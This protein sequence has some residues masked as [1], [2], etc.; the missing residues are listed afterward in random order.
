MPNLQERLREAA[1]EDGASTTSRKRKEPA[2]D[3]RDGERDKEKE[4]DRDRDRGERER[5]REKDREPHRERTKD[6]DR[7]TRSS[8][9]HRYDD[10]ETERRSSRD[11]GRE[12]E[13]DIDREKDRDGYRSS[14]H[15]RDSERDDRKRDREGGRDRERKS[16]RGDHGSGYWDEA[17]L[18]KERERSTSVYRD[19]PPREKR[20]HDDKVQDSRAEK[21]KVIIAPFFP[22]HFNETLQRP[23]YDYD[24]EDVDA[25]EVDRRHDSARAETPEEGEI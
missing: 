11:Y 8:R 21:V 24:D 7:G 25:M 22:S 5:E 10:Y 15:H 9:H 20:D 18:K 4:R 6:Y 17:P 2:R 19:E 16:S 1:S 13:K 14:K 12:R 3:H 23:R